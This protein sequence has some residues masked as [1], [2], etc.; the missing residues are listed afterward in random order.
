MKIFNDKIKYD[1]LNN[2]FFI[3]SIVLSFI[4]T[5]INYLVFDNVRWGLYFVSL[6]VNLLISFALFYRFNN[7]FI[8]LLTGNFG[9]KRDKSIKISEGEKEKIKELTQYCNKS[10]VVLKGEENIYQMIKT[11]DSFFCKRCNGLSLAN[12]ITDFN[13]FN[14]PNGKKHFEIKFSEIKKLHYKVDENNDV[15]IYITNGINRFYFKLVFEYDKKLLEDFLLCGNLERKNLFKQREEKK[16]NKTKEDKERFIFNTVAMLG[17]LTSYQVMQYDGFLPM[18]NWWFALLTII[19]IFCLVLLVIWSFKKTEKYQV[20]KFFFSKERHNETGYEVVQ[21]LIALMLCLPINEYTLDLGETLVYS[22]VLAIVF[23]V[24]LYRKLS[25]CRAKK[26]FLRRVIG[27]VVLLIISTLG[28]VCSANEV[29]YTDVDYQRCRVIEYYDGSDN[30][31][32]ATI[33]IDGENHSIPVDN[34]SFNEN[35]PYVKIA[36][37]TGLLGIDYVVQVE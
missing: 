13:S 20:V 5:F 26:N 10:I 35:Q 27:T 25:Q 29:Y 8:A 11:K 17:L 15:I 14:K 23:F 3:V 24:I 19:A 31:R 2:Y 36:R 12:F 16:S 18:K 6:F 4:I 1:K 22:L 32:F 33:N 28:I 34:E 9:K 30:D 7:G 37:V 21:L